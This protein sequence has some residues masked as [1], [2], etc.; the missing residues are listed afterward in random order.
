MKKRF[1]M[2][3]SKGST[4]EL[5]VMEYLD[6]K[7]MKYSSS[8]YGTCRNYIG[9]VMDKHTGKK[10]MKDLGFSVET[11]YYKPKELLG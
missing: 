7:G 10:I 5:R 3:V 4:D 8:E 6:K 2:T 11:Y 9:V 1:V